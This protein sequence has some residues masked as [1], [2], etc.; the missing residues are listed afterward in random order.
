MLVKY[1]HKYTKEINLLSSRSS[2]TLLKD[3]FLKFLLKMKEIGKFGQGLVLNI[4][5]FLSKKYHYR[6]IF[7]PGGLFTPIGEVIAPAYTK[8]ICYLIVV[9][10]NKNFEFQNNW[11]KIIHFECNCTQLCPILLC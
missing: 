7:F 8:T 11:L 6:R 9:I 10:I 3:F 1:N 5:N 4:L 2:M